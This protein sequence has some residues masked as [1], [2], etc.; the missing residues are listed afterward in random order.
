MRAEF[1]L[2]VKSAH[3]QRG[4]CANVSDPGCEH[5][6]RPRW[7]PQSRACQHARGPEFSTSWPRLTDTPST[8]L[9]RWNALGAGLG[10]GMPFGRSGRALTCAGVPGR[11]GGA[12]LVHPRGEPW[13]D[14][15]LSQ[16]ALQGPSL[17]PL[18]CYL[19]SNLN[20]ARVLALCGKPC[21]TRAYPPPAS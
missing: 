8:V 13:A 6:R 17:G 10:G 2:N 5:W 14:R 1:S 21:R 19:A 20:R 12:S 16:Q 4:P 3:R 15:H 18:Q 7:W 11:L 9:S